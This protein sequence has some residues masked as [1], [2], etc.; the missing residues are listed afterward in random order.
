MLLERAIL[1][2][3]AYSD[4]F[5]Y[6]LTLTEIYKYLIIS[7]TME[8]IENCIVKMNQVNF[9][10]NFYFLTGRDEIVGTRQL[11]EKKSRKILKRAILYGKILGVFP[12]VRMVGLTGSLAMLNLSQEIDMD[13]M[14]ITQP[15]R[16]WLARAF[17]V[18]FGRIMRFAG[19]RICVNLLLSKNTL[20]WKEHDLYSAREIC[21]MIPIV[22][23]DAYYDFRVANLWTQE[24]LPNVP[25]TKNESMQISWL[26]KI[27]EFPF[28]GKFGDLLE[29]WVMTFQLNIIS[30][31]A[32]NS[33]ESNFS[34]DICQ[35]NFH[36]HKKCTLE[37]Y[38]DRLNML[39]PPSS[40][41]AE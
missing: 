7:A 37:T 16:L 36:Q 25:M 39:H 28:L 23:F 2:T 27:F 20:L 6:P 8:E 24:V 29:K 9:K 31:N 11:R 15:K 30:K 32:G 17:A 5:D 19:D 40:A 33:D 12:F 18:T 1:E 10:N 14:L 4:I 3:L 13:F 35:G 26:P 21:Q 41:D 22:G 34:P 38:K